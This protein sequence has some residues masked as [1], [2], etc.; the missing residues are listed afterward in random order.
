MASGFR[1][2][3]LITDLVM[4]DIS[5]T[6]AAAQ[7]C[8]T[9]PD[10]KVIIFSGQVKGDE[11]KVRAESAGCVMDIIAKPLHPQ[12]LLSKIRILMNR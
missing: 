11:L 9:L 2:D 4:P 5:G 1:P 8:K 6:D 10:I 7:I 3:M 12:E